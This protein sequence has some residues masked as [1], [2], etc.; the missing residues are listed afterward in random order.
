M[1]QFLCVS[2]KPNLSFRFHSGSLQ[3]AIDECERRGIDRAA[4]EMVINPKPHA[5]LATAPDWT[6]Y[7][8]VKKKTYWNTAP[9][10]NPE[11]EARE[12][13]AREKKARKERLEGLRRL[14]SDVPLHHSVIQLVGSRPRLTLAEIAWIKETCTETIKFELD[15]ARQNAR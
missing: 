6:L 14:Y 12:K 11:K 7:R 8:L 4:W 3:T 2:R 9:R 10:F 13:E 5:P 15:I 1:L